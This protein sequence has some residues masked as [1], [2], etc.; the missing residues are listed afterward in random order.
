MGKHISS[1]FLRIDMRRIRSLILGPE[2]RDKNDLRAK[3]GLPPSQFITL[4]NGVNA[5]LRD[6]GDPKAP[7]IILV[8]GHSEDMQTWNQLVK[9]LVENFR[10]VRYD[11]RRHGLTGPAPDNEYRIENYVSDLSMVVDH[12][13]INNFVLLGHSMGGRISVKYTMENPERVN[14]IILL[15]ASGAPRKEKTSQPLALRLMK[16]SIGRFLIKRIWSRNM[17]QKSLSDMVFDGSSITDEEVDRMWDLSRYPGNMDAMF[18]EFA[19]SWEDFN[20]AE[21]RTITTNA[22]LIWGKEDLICPESMGRWYDSQLPNSTM[23]ELP[24]IGHNPQFECPDRCSDEILS[25]IGKLS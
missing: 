19:D 6:E 16:N 20:Q 15:S 3:Y 13:G 1:S 11:L 25:W 9:K 22:L 7:A 21:I 8:H 4:S 18:R 24:N 14:S 2:K 17:A 23:V 5:H 10:V 12:L